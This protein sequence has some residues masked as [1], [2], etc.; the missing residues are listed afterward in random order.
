MDTAGAAAGDVT[1]DGTPT[2]LTG[3]WPAII[4]SPTWLF[5]GELTI[6]SS[7]GDGII[8]WSLLLPPPQPSGDTSCVGLKLPI[9]GV[10]GAELSAGKFK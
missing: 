5:S 7:C 1:F 4:D 3:D 8:C 9:T 2:G 10:S 6:E